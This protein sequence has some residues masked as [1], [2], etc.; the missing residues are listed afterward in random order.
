MIAPK[1]SRRAPTAASSHVAQPAPVNASEL[2]GVTGGVA[3]AA[4]VGGTVELP[5][6]AAWVVVVGAWVVVGAAVEVVG[7]AVGGGMTGEDPVGQTG[8]TNVVV[9]GHSSSH[10]GLVV[11]VEGAWVVVVGAWVVVVTWM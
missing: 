8:G 10:G 3:G 6:T 9:V 11:V 1:S 2:V 7:A 4:V 5:R